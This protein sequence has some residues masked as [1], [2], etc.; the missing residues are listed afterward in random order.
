MNLW[1]M[2][3][4]DWPCA[5]GDWLWAVLVMAPVL[6]LDRLTWRK[7][8]H[9]AIRL[10]VVAVFLICIHYVFNMAEAAMVLT[11]D[12]ATWEIGA[13]LAMMAAR[14][15]AIQGARFAVHTVRRGLRSGAVRVQ[16]FARRQRRSVWRRADPPPQSDDEP[17]AAWAR[18]TP[19]ALA[20]A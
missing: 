2:L 17:G 16:R 15:F 10:L 19:V 13:A 9:L 8:R 5:L 3:T 20:W 11:I 1:Q 4:I 12:G 7:A 14:G 18:Y 6:W